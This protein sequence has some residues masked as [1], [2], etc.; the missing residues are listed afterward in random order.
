MK[1]ALVTGMSRGVGLEIADRLLAN[2]WEVIGVSRTPPPE[3]DPPLYPRRR[4][5]SL[6]VTD[7][8]Y[9]YGLAN[10]LDHRPVDAVYHCAALACPEAHAAGVREVTLH[11]GPFLPCWT[12]LAA[13]GAYDG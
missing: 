10:A 7:P 2:G 4:W 13:Q 9:T 5:H 8:R 12:D 6:D 1:R 11:V 3:A